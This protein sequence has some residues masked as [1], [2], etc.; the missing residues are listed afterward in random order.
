MKWRR[1]NGE[2]PE[3][4]PLPEPDGARFAERWM[5]IGRLAPLVLSLLLGV[6]GGT[7][8]VLTR[9]G[10]AASPSYVD[11]AVA[12]AAS[13]LPV[14]VQRLDLIERTQLVTTER[15]RAIMEQLDRIE[16]RI[17]GQVQP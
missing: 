10:C 1:G 4:G 12:R 8:L 6:A 15:L 3:P 13:P 14:L 16:T 9:A 5:S 2:T 7:A 11:L 17:G